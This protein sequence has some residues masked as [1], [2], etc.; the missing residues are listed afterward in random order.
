MFGSLWPYGV[1]VTHQAPLSTGFPRQEYWNGLPFPSPGDLPDPGIE[2]TSP[3]WLVDSLPLSH[4]GSPAFLFLDY[5]FIIKG[6][7]SVTARWKRYIRQ[8]IWKGEQSF[9]ALSTYHS[10]PIAKCLPAQN[11][12]SFCWRVLIELNLELPF[13]SSS[14]RWTAGSKNF[15]HL[16][17]CLSGDQSYLKPLWGPSPRQVILLA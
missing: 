8:G 11:L 4:L 14:Q 15:N 2:P 10:A 7:S 12:N 16:I 1:Y 13:S 17:T 9:H 5:Q 6:H 3:A